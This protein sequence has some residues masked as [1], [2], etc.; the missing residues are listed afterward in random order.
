MAGQSLAELKAAFMKNLE[1]LP[2]LD[3]RFNMVEAPLFAGW[4]RRPARKGPPPAPKPGL[5]WGG[6]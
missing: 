1:R 4:R 6:P 2:H 3:N 5:E